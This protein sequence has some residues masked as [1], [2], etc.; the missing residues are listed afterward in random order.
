MS[1][2]G[3]SIRGSIWLLGAGL[4]WSSVKGYSVRGS[5]KFLDLEKILK[6][7]GKRI[8]GNQV[9]FPVFHEAAAPSMATTRAFAESHT[10]L[11]RHALA[12]LLKLR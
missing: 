11:D 9:K 2:V 8:Q 7:H 1:R 12:K 3:Y 4:H 6:N 10:T 5:A